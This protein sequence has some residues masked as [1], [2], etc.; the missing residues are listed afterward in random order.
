MKLVVCSVYDSSVG[1]YLQPFFTR[2]KGEAIRSFI[3]AVKEEKGPFNRHKKD[4]TLMFLGE[5]DDHDAS[6][7]HGDVYAT[8]MLS[9][10]EASS[11]EE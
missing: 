8:P 5:W 4:F 2:S 10:L 3:D 9:A 7:A 1:A 6:F 11:R